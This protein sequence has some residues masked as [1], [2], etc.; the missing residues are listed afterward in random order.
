MKKTSFGSTRSLKKQLTEVTMV[1]K[2]LAAIIFIMMPFLGFFIGLMVEA[3]N[4][5]FF[6]Y[7]LGI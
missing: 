2:T 4:P 5:G 1:S 6:H 3:Q 7:L